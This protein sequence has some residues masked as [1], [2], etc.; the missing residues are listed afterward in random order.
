[1]PQVA[2]DMANLA[3]RNC[4]MFLVLGSSLVVY[5]AAALPEIA[6]SIGAILVIVNIDPTPLDNIADIVINENVSKVLSKI[7]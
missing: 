3:A 6:K 1:L 4:D 2:L 5:P 7:I